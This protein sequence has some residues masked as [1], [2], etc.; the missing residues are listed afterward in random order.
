M[1]Y[2]ILYLTL[3][4][5]TEKSSRLIELFSN[6]LKQLCF[7]KNE[8]FI[9]HL[10]TRWWDWGKHF[11]NLRVLYDSSGKLNCSR[12]KKHTANVLIISVCNCFL[13]LLGDT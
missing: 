12:F 13:S 2:V 7:S 9:K 3:V 11:L 4:A 5:I 10:K 8:T 1:F 6:C